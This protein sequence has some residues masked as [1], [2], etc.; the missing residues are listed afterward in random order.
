MGL[1]E[2]TQAKTTTKTAARPTAAPAKIFSFDLEPPPCARA[3]RGGRVRRQ[4]VRRGCLRQMRGVSE[5]GWLRAREARGGGVLR[6]RAWSAEPYA[7]EQSPGEG[8]QT[9][10]LEGRA[11]EGFWALRA[12]SPA[13]PGAP[14]ASCSVRWIVLP[15]ITPAALGP[16][17]VT[18]ISS[19]ESFISAHVSSGA[20]GP[21]SPAR[22][23]APPTH[24]RHDANRGSASARKRG[25]EQAAP[26]CLQRELDSAH[27]SPQPSIA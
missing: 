13:P 18:S 5:E 8:R 19:A 17:G 2:R 27:S 22:V 7:G 25:C 20:T 24:R 9:W 10:R 23:S 21:A 26:S 3:R 15:P 1:R 16:G 11:G 14:L 6:P 12:A 4:S